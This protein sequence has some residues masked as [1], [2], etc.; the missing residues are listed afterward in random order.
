MNL[1]GIN[2]RD[3]H[4]QLAPT[5][6]ATLVYAT[7]LSHIVALTKE[8]RRAGV[9]AEYVTGDTPEKVRNY[10][11]EQFRNRQLPVL[12]NYEVFAEGTDIPAVDCIIMARPTKS[13]GLYHQMVGRG[14]R[15][16]S[17]KVDC[18]ILDFVDNTGQHSLS[19][20]PVL[21]STT[22]D[23]EIH[24]DELDKSKC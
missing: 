8:F 15:P 19:A 22:G 11:L 13:T 17:G 12:I 2:N 1:D 3:S 6:K 24:E 9:M 16:H 4:Y 23:K 18:L 21:W 10:L 5:R 7:S 20:Q 14:L